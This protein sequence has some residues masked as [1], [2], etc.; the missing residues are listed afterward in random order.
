MS[1]PTQVNRASAAPEQTDSQ[2]A[3]CIVT[4]PE[5][6][7]A[8]R[9]WLLSAAR[10]RKMAR[11]EWARQGVALLR[12]G[13]VFTAVRV[14]MTLVQS[15]AQTE[16]RRKIGVYLDGALHGGAVFTCENSTHAYFLVP[17][18]VWR[19]WRT[20]DSECLTAGTLLGVP[21][22]EPRPDEPSRW[23]LDMGGPG[24]LCTREAVRQ[25]VMYGRYCAAQTHA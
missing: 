25:L 12:C 1:N 14:P 23:L 5:R 8:V 17:A 6:R 19:D 2:P 3:D 9:T 22:P 10:N 13:G 15:A 21:N 11:R 24:E 7:A 4:G 20:P 18:M 16:D